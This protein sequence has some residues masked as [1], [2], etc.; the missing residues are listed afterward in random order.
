MW[1]LGLRP[2]YSFSG[3]ICF[4]LSAFCLCSVDSNEKLG[5]SERWQWLGISLGLWQSMAIHNLNMQFLCKNL[6]PFPIAPDLVTCDVLTNF[7]TS[8][9]FPYSRCENFQRQ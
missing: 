4:K 9:R 5:G 7:T 6:F 3:N 2:R 1:K 8:I